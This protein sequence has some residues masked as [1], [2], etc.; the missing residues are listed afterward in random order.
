MAF[1]TRCPQATRVAWITAWGPDLPG[2]PICP[3]VAGSKWLTMWEWEGPAPCLSVRQCVPQ[4]AL[5]NQGEAEAW[6]HTHAQLF[7]CFHLL[8]HSLLDSSWKHFIDILLAS[9]S[10]THGLMLGT[11]F[12]TRAAEGRWWWWWGGWILWIILIMVKIKLHWVLTWGAHDLCLEH[13]GGWGRMLAVSVYLASLG[14]LW[15]L[16]G[17][18][19]V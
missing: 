11:W 17:L 15:C 12:K 19:V 6:N 10:Q 5:C 14:D 3:E 9:E 4:N 18:P 2:V 7:P 13:V 8:S 1:F 16:L